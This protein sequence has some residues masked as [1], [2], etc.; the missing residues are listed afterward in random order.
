ML[1]PVAENSFSDGDTRGRG[2]TSYLPGH[3]RDGFHNSGLDY[4]FAREDTPS[5]RVWTLG[6]V[7]GAQIAM[8]IDGIVGDILVP[9]DMFNK[10]RQLR[11]CYKELEIRLPNFY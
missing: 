6:G 7:V 3:E 4:F 8:L 11:R 2:E 9:G 10:P 1:H 5:D